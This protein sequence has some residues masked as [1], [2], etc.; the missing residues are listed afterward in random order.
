MKELFTSDDHP[1]AI[2]C[3]DFFRAEQTRIALESFGLSVPQD[4]ALMCRTAR[5]WRYKHKMIY[6]GFCARK[7]DVFAEAAKQIIEEIENRT[8]VSNRVTYMRPELI[9]GNSVCDRNIGCEQ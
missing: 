4:V 3:Q 7:Y 8:A 6:E 1:D 9:K 5:S 2:I